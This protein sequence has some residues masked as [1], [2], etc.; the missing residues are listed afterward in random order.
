[1][2]RWLD[3]SQWLLVAGMFVI[4]ILVWPV[5]PDQLPV[6]WN[7]SGAVDRYGGKPEGLFLLPQSLLIA[8]PVRVLPRG[9]I[10][11]ANV[12]SSFRTRCR[13]CAWAWSSP[14][15]ASTR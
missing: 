14:W 13:C 3:L 4:G 1:M 12:T 8:G 5:A 6:H 11:T 10:H 7:L 9:S 2:K 15:P